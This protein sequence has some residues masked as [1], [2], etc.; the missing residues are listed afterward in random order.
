MTSTAE[1]A[2]HSHLKWPAKGETLEQWPR[3]AVKDRIAF[4]MKDGDAIPEASRPEP[5]DYVVRLSDSEK[6]KILQHNAM[7]R[8]HEIQPKVHNP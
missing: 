8:Q 3:Y 5:E 2:I 6:A 4:R 1:R 7:A